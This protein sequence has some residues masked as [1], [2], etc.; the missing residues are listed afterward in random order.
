MSMAARTTDPSKNLLKALALLAAMSALGVNAAPVKSQTQS[1][2]PGRASSEPGT[3]E[4]YNRRL[5]QLRQ[6]LQPPASAA[7]SEEYRI[8]PDDLLE[9]SVFEAPELNRSP[10]VSAGGEIS[11]PLLGPVPSAGLTPRE[12]ESVLEE[13]LRR[14]FMK[15]PHVSVFVRE[16]QSHPVSV[17]GAV[18]RPG[19]FQIRGAKSLVEVLSMAEGLAEDAGDTVLVIRGAGSAARAVSNAEPRANHPVEP[20]GTGEPGS[21][22]AVVPAPASSQTLEVD[23]KRLLDSGDPGAN[24]LVY[25][26]DVVKVTRAGIVYVVGEVKKPGGYLLKSNENITV[27]QALALAEG[28]TRTAAKRFA[29]II[30]TEESTGK[31]AEIPID[32][33]RIMAGRAL[34]PPLRPRD[35]VLVPN[36]TARTGLYRGAEAAVSVVSGLIVFRR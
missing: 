28:L 30:R 32:L 22:A 3:A 24:L 6:I 21:P 31:R 4:E 27:L 34:D 10:R 20:A 26:G 17:F 1:A 16:M 7:S 5:E 35:I 23:L 8:G 11:L 36:S 19:V 2:L 14:T 12:L 15:D 29:R 13:L 33:G 9:I 25:P 18:K